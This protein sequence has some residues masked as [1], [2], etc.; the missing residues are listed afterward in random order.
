MEP[1]KYSS[2]AIWSVTQREREQSRRLSGANRH[3]AVATHNCGYQTENFSL[4]NRRIAS[5]QRVTT[6]FKPGDCCVQT[7]DNAMRNQAAA[8][9]VQDNFPDRWL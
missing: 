2:N 5:G 8:S 6:R 7:A 4:D 9:G 1:Q 3:F